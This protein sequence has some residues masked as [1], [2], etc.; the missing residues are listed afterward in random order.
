VLAW[1]VEGAITSYRVVPGK[2]R[3]VREALEEWR[4]EADPVLGFF[5]DRLELDEGSAIAASD[6]YSEFGAYLEA[7][8]QQRWSDQLIAT[9][10]TGHSSLDGVT[11]RQVRYGHGMTPSRPPFAIKPIPPR[12]TSWVGIRFRNEQTVPSEAERDAANLADLERRAG[13]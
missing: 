10:M 3:H 8:G 6:L 13:R 5:R 2:P 1:L 4:G 7:R 9:S 11:K 12:A